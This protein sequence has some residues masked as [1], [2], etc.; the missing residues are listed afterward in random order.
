[1]EKIKFPGAFVLLACCIGVGCNK[2][3][4]QDSSS[5]T[6]SSNSILETASNAWQS[7]KET[8][9]NALDATKATA[10][11]AWQDTK[12][13]GSNVWQKTKDAF[14][15]GDS[16]NEVSTN[17]FGY[18]Y[19]QKDNFVNEARTS[20]D[21][22]DQKALSLSNRVATASDNTKADLQQTLDNINTKRADLG[23][24]L[25]DIKNAT[26]DNWNDAKTAFAKSYHDLKAELKAGWDSVTSKL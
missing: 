2:Q 16:T 26:Q 21:D 6:T 25:D 15:A 22:L 5:G 1:M 18:D 4:D 9:T 10:T 8:G 19:S 11:N 14:A 7:A 23:H 12:E 24:K 3:A 13:T 17:Y 20:L